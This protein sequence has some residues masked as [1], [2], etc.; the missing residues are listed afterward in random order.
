MVDKD[1]F[2][3]KPQVVPVVFV[4]RCGHRFPYSRTRPKDIML[5]NTALNLQSIRH[6]R[7]CMA[8]GASS[9]RFAS[10]S[11]AAPSALTVLLVFSIS[12]LFGAVINNPLFR[13]H[14]DVKKSKHKYPMFMFD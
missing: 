4:E 11:A 12:M 1:V 3:Y 2:D 9:E 7:I 14:F 13:F 8:A 5:F 6:G 10:F